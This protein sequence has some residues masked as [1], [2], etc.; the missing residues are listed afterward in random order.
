MSKFTVESIVASI[1]EKIAVE[2]PKVFAG[3]CVKLSQKTAESLAMDYGLLK[4]LRGREGGSHP[5]DKG[6]SFAGVDIEAYKTQ[7]AH[8]KKLLS[9]Q[10]KSDN[11]QKKLKELKDASVLPLAPNTPVQTDEEAAPLTVQ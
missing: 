1:V 4:A 5:T 3:D 11:L 8:D 9:L 6:L 10:R 2:V 7:Q